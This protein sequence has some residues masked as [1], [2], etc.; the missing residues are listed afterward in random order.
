MK[1]IAYKR[2]KK[3]PKKQPHAIIFDYIVIIAMEVSFFLSFSVSY[4]NRKICS[5]I[6]KYTCVSCFKRIMEILKIFESNKFP[7]V[8]FV[9]GVVVNKTTKRA[10][11]EWGVYVW[12][13]ETNASVCS[14]SRIQ[15]SQ[16]PV[17]LSLTTHD[18]LMAKQTKQQSNKPS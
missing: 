4:W 13:R 8:G 3:Y 11:C 15:F 5:N 2:N 7:V 6:C 12:R 10:E 17:K 9:V 18:I 1:R 16:V 14:F